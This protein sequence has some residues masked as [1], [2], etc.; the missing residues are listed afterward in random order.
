MTKLER[1]SVYFAL[2]HQD[3]LVQRT[4]TLFHMGDSVTGARKEDGQTHT[5]QRYS[6]ARGKDDAAASPTGSARITFMDEKGPFAGL[7]SEACVLLS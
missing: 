1:C 6:A 4:A 2:S 3:S 5:F 7:L